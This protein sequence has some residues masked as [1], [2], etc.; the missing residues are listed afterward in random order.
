[1]P[2]DQILERKIFMRRYPDIHMPNAAANGA[3]NCRQ[4]IYSRRDPFCESVVAVLRLSKRRNLLSKYSED[5]L[6]G[7]AGLKTGKERI[8]GQVFLSPAFVGFQRSVEN[9][10]KIGMRGGH[11]S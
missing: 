1:M 5:S 4:E 7:I 6:G 10:H 9:G 3:T 11:D 8:R 2:E